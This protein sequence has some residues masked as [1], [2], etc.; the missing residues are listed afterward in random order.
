MNQEKI[1]DAYKRWKQKGLPDVIAGSPDLSVVFGNYNYSNIYVT[2][3]TN[4]TTYIQKGVPLSD[5]VTIIQV[6]KELAEK[7]NLK[8]VETKTINYKLDLFRVSSYIFCKIFDLKD[9]IKEN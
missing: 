4:N 3:Y 2:V 8:E 5:E 9:K 6:K 1:N 7:L